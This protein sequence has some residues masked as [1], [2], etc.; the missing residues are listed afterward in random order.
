M[1]FLFHTKN[2]N[3]LDA[4]ISKVLYSR[5]WNQGQAKLV[6][7]GRPAIRPRRDYGR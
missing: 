1:V 7:G 3:N 6:I 2:E 4:E 5:G